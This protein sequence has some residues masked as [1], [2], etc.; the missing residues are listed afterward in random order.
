MTEYLRPAVKSSLDLI[1]NTPMLELTNFDTGLCRLFVKLEN[2]NSRR[3]G[4]RTA[5]ANR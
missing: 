3:L 5:S 4:S 2:Q 1:G